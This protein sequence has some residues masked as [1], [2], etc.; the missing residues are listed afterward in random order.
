M[1][2]DIFGGGDGAA[3][4]LHC[5]GAGLLIPAPVLQQ[6]YTRLHSG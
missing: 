4:A 5:A 2:P 6:Y 1:S 3:A